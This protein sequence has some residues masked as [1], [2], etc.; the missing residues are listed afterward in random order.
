MV[1]DYKQVT[2]SKAGCSNKFWVPEDTVTWMYC[3]DEC[4]NA[5]LYG[6]PT[7]AA[8]AAAEEAT[9]IAVFETESPNAGVERMGTDAESTVPSVSGGG[10]LAGDAGA[11]G[12]EL[13]GEPDAAGGGTGVDGVV[14]EV[15]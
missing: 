7:A 4:S 8:A 13:V 2:C 5:E 6:L 1:V 9:A 11:V 12:Q 3:S 14:S 15:G 10:G